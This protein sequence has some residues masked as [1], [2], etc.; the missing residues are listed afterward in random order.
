[1]TQPIYLVIGCPGSGKSWVCEQLRDQYAY[2][3]HDD[4]LNGG[5]LDAIKTIHKVTTKPLLIETPF[6]ISQV[7]DPLEK[8]ALPVVPV[9]IQEHHDVIR[10]RYRERGSGDLPAGHLAR[11]LTYRQRAQLWQ[12][13]Q[14]TSQQVLEYLKNAAPLVIEE[15]FPRETNQN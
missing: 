11:Q 8:A 2:V 12:S 3:R 5:Y 15:K 1:M 6:S 14:G 7:K 9:F 4:Y 13:F 10:K